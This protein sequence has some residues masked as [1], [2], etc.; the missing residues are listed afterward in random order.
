MVTNFTSIWSS[1]VLNIECWSQQHHWHSNLKELSSV[2]PLIF[3]IYW[4]FSSVTPLIFQIYWVLSSVTPLALQT[5]TIPLYICHDTE[6]QRA[7]Q[8]EPISEYI[9]E[10]SFV[11]VRGRQWR[12][13]HPRP[14]HHLALMHRLLWVPYSLW[15]F[16][17]CTPQ[18]RL[19]LLLLPFPLIVP[20]FDSPSLWKFIPYLAPADASPSPVHTHSQGR[21]FL[22]NIA[23]NSRTTGVFLPMDKAWWEQISLPW[24]SQHSN[25]SFHRFFIPL[26]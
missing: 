25:P 21:H 1:Q 15:C 4:I 26:T 7:A 19:F 20:S 18:F 16:V 6:K 24:S 9:P 11:D 22:H 8:Y 3:Q 14:P 2:T 23:A 5:F 10:R 12:W 17:C 13:D